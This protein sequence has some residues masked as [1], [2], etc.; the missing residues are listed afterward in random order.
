MVCSKYVE[1]K[2]SAETRYEK[3]YG[4]KQHK[5]V[6]DDHKTPHIYYL[7]RILWVKKLRKST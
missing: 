2:I 5:R 1:L 7:T 6:A 3:V 4:I